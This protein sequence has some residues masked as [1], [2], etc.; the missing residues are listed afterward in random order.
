MFGAACSTSA[1]LVLTNGPP[2]E[3]T[4]EGSDTSSIVLTEVGGGPLSL[5]QKDVAEIDHPGNVAALIALPFLAFGIGILAGV[6]AAETRPGADGMLGLGSAMGWS[7]I[8]VGAPLL[9]TGGPIWV[10]SK[11]RA[12][13]F[14]SARPPAWMIPPAPMPPSFD[15]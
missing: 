15:R 5:Q 6:R 9:L 13:R 3:A 10:R 8:V 14:E 11:L 12:R 2:L 1:T 7:S 4:I